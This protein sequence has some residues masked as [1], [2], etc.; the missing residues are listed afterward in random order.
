MRSIPLDDLDGSA[1]ERVDDWI[2][3]CEERAE[4]CETESVARLGVFGELCGIAMALVEL[5]EILSSD[6]LYALRVDVFD[7][8]HQEVAGH[9]EL[10]LPKGKQDRIFAGI[11][12]GS[13]AGDEGQRK[14][15]GFR[16]VASLPDLLEGD[17]EPRSVSQRV[18]LGY[19]L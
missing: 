16:H 2:E 18:G 12:G 5:A 15:S 8:R 10:S 19:L 7:T 9:E 3:G 17:S 6:G 1:G 14:T 13:M 4:V 11:L